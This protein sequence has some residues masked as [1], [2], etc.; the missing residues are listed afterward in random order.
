M[1]K[2]LGSISA[3]V[4]IGYAAVLLI[5]VA[6]AF[7][8]TSTTSTVQGRVTIFVEQTLP[9][10]SAIE[11]VGSFVSRL[12]ILAYSLYGTT[13]SV[14][15]FDQ[16]Q[17]ELK[18]QLEHAL[19]TLN[20]GENKVMTG[21]LTAALASLDN[22]LDSLRGI[23]AA[24]SIDWDGARENLANLSANATKVV[25]ELAVI[26]SSVSD[27][28]AHSSQMIID[29]MSGT[30]KLI[31][32]LVTGIAAVAIVAYVLARKQI[33]APIGALASSLMR[34]AGDRDLTMQLPQQSS[35]EVGQ[36]AQSVNE[37]L[38]VFR[39]GM[40]D[41]STAIAGI[42]QSV[43]ALS[44][45]A[46]SS[47]DTVNQMNTEIEK[48]VSVMTQLED[49]IERGVNCSE[50]A[51][52]SAQ[53]GASE[54]QTGAEEVERTAASIDSLASDIESTAEMLLE[55]RT[56]GDQVSGVVSTIADIADQTNLLALNAAIEAARAG[57][58]GR[59]FAVV[60]D[61]VRT[62]ATRT[63]ESTVEIN[64]MLEKIVSSI[65]ASVTTMTSNQEKAKQSVELAQNTVESLSNIK[66]TIHG[67]SSECD[68]AASLAA[69]ARQEVA[70]VHD[71]VHRFKSL[72]DAVGEGS[73]ET[74]SSSS[75][76]SDLATRLQTLAAKF[77]V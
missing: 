70:T 61:E 46:S 32:M 74:Q 22:S 19:K 51:S 38:G 57:E 25:E 44:K 14:G 47:D 31:A 77:K 27:G 6:A 56:S 72:G 33:A 54:V 24:S 23:M 15:D 64:A 20:D 35:D 66:Q 52:A 37:L 1:N 55:L 48:L 69:G 16:Q 60:A 39:E 17:S 68:E 59:G 4:L 28:A 34:I 7:T 41:V 9:Q 5:T 43:N 8:L 36:T 2:L 45:T 11:Q 29:D 50:S 49:Q 71:Q 76:L 75:S 3:K 13:T 26:K 58:S 53:R 62:L 30:V 18:D 63:H 21:A 67:L 10:L 65:T 12:E 40:T 42:S 73:R